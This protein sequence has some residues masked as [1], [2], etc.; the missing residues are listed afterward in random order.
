LS[1]DL[2]DGKTGKK[3]ENEILKMDWDGNIVQT[4]KLSVTLAASFCVEND[5]TLYFIVQ[6]IVDD[7][8][9]YLIL[10]YHF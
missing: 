6:N 8:E 9:E 7:E 3:V 4:I 10:S 5:H 1:R 2:Y